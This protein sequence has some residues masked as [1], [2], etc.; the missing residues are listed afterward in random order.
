MYLDWTII[1]ILPG[2]LLG[3]W[4]QSRVKNAFEK[5]SKVH[6]RIGR[7]S[8]DLVRELLARQGVVD[9]AIS[10]TQGTLSDHY[11]PSSNTLRLSQGVFGSDS[12]AAVGIAAHEAGH[13]LQKEQGYQLLSLRSLMVPVVNI[14]ST[15]AWPIFVLGI[16]FSFKPLMYVGIAVFAAVVVFSLITLPVEFDASRKAN[17]MLSESG[18]FTQEELS[19]VRTVLNAAALTYVASFISTLMQLLRLVLIARRRND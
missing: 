6:T 19:G 16:I 11:D 4:A 15:L 1:L 13:A 3:L 17:I 9:I 10:P 8:Q 12:V 5:Y 7:A 2:L 14:G 18:Y